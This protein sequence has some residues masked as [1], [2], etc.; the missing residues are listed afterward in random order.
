MAKIA[1]S[2]LGAT[3]IV[4]Q[5]LV[6][7]L[8]DHPWF[9]IEALCGSAES[10]GLRYSEALKGRW[11]APG[12]V[13]A[14]VKDMILH[15][16][17]PGPA[18]ARVVFSALDAE[19]AGP[20]E[21]EYARAG[22][23][24]FSN[25]KAH[26]FGEFVPLVVPEVNGDHLRLLE[27]QSSAPGGIVTNPNCS[28]AGLV[29][30]LAPLHRRFTVR[31]VFVT[32]M[33]AL[34]GAGYPGVAALDIA[35]NVLPHIPGEEEKMETEPRKILGDGLT[36]ADIGISA[37]CN[38]VATTEGHLMTVAVELVE[39]PSVEEAAAVMAS[40]SPLAGRG[41]PTAPDRPLFLREESDRPQPVLDAGR[42]GGMTVTVGRLRT[43]P[44]LHLRFALLV[45][46]LVRGA[47]GA[48]VLNAELARAMG[49]GV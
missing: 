42:G 8:A 34:S 18:G 40:F 47:A 25:A 16:C 15:E 13:P 44:L 10:A 36:A 2:I 7:R 32:T 48:A 37:Q 35:G 11:R 46:N 17:R 43:D 22:S 3:G 33:Q 12:D 31:R 39:R 38:R 27:R 26:R 23:L 45:N 21:A 28:T 30:A 1:V 49:Y 20:I 5:R 19:A 6:A 14:R 4:G 24:V 9:E 29:L 41:L